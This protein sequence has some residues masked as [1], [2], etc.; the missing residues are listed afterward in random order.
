[1]GGQVAGGAKSTMIRSKTTRYCGWRG[2]KTY[3]E[4]VVDFFRLLGNNNTRKWLTRGRWPS[5][6]GNGES[7]HDRKRAK[8]EKILHPPLVV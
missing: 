4:K 1:M 3:V 2:E 5:P 6:R 8:R 7:G